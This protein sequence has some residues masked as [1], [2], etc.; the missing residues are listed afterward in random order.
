LRLRWRERT[1]SRAF[2][3]FASD[4]REKA[5]SSSDA[6]PHD[7]AELVWRRSDDVSV[8]RER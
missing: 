4:A 1:G 8:T 5:F 2:T 7:L 3:L 6:V